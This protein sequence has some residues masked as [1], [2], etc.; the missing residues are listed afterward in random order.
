MS[1]SSKVREI[2]RDFQSKWESLQNQIISIQNNHDIVDHLKA[3]QVEKLQEQQLTAGTEA[4]KKIYA[5]REEFKVAAEKAAANFTGSANNDDVIALQSG[6]DLSPVQF[7]AIIERNK[8]NQ[9]V[10]SLARK[11]RQRRMEEGT[12]E[13]L[14]TIS[15]PL[16]IDK[17]VEN[18]VSFTSTAIEVCSDPTGNSSLKRVIFIE[19]MSD[20]EGADYIG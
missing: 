4:I 14:Y 1:Y 11:Y 9:L 16:P 8:K 19:S 10:L 2:V 6:I 20:P 15:V 18:F 7:A 5:V 12:G 17:I 13:E 3:G